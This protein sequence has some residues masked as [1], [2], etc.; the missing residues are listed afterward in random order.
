LKQIRCLVRYIHASVPL[1]SVKKLAY[2]KDW[3]L[4]LNNNCGFNNTTDCYRYDFR[5]IT[6]KIQMSRCC[7]FSCFQLL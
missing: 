6:S 4:A 3:S 5:F 1:D 7:Q 2:L